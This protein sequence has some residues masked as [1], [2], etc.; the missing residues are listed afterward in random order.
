MISFVFEWVYK[1]TY[2]VKRYKE[3]NL[4]EIID[5]MKVLGDML[6]PYNFPKSPPSTTMEDALAFFKE[7]EAMIDGYSV[8]LNYQKSDYDSHLL[9]TLQIYNKNSPFLPF[10]LTCKLAQRFLGSHHLSLVEL[11]KDNRKIYCWS[12]CVDKEGHPI[13]SPYN[14]ETEDCNFEGFNYLYM[15]PSQVN[16]F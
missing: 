13:A 4:D 2:M 8:Y 3:P 11:F 10:G 5:T 14:S 1:V 15:H 9:E 6:I 16:F 12:V 7:R